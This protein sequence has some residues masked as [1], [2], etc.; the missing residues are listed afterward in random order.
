MNIKELK[1]YYL[2]FVKE[3]IIN[4]T[5]IIYNNRID[6]PKEKEVKLKNDLKLDINGNKKIVSKIRSLLFDIKNESDVY[7]KNQDIYLSISFEKIEKK[8]KN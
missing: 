1:K 6:Y 4:S 5:N 2:E 7:L 3:F 8:E